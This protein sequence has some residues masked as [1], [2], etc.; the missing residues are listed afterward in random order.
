METTL[1]YNWPFALDVL[2][3][4]YDAIP[5]QRLLAFQSQY[6][7]KIGPNMRLGLFGQEGY[8]TTDP[9]NI[10]AI[11]S[12]HFEDWGL[13][14]RRPG[15]YPLL[16]EGIFTQEGKPWR[17]S[18]EILRRQ[19][20]RIQYQNLK[21]FD[22]H[23]NDLISG[24]TTA[25][26]DIVDLQ[27]FFFKFTLAT[28]TDLIF[29]EPVGMLDDDVQDTFAN[30][31]DYASMIS[32]LRLRLADFHWLYKPKKFRDACAVVKQYADHFVGQALKA[33]DKIGQEAAYEKYPFILDL[34][35]DLKDPFLV[36]DQ[37]VHVLIAGRDTT[38]C[39]MSWAMF[40]LVRHPEVLAKL[41]KQIMSVIPEAHRLYPQ[42]PVNVRIALRTTILPSGGGPD[43]KSPVLV[44]KGT[45]CGW[46]TYHMHRMTSLYGPG[47]NEF[48]PERWED[49]DLE[50]DIGWGFMPFHGGPRLCLGKDFALSEA[51]Y[52]LVKI[53][54]TFPNIRLPEGVRGEGTGMEKQNLTIVVTSAEGCKVLLR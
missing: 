38:A 39:L 26:D 46:S 4:Q 16:G 20:V 27:P 22:E 28:T 15:L 7:N 32:A 23:I 9:K 37:L 45:G 25:G 6:F 50:K 34:Y 8:M 33:R 44:R 54:Q 21:V 30:N 13:G 41:R 48:V 49:T 10:E 11:L 43:R 52:A 24:L 51:S 2:K 12:T 35:E 47:A 29:G 14:S 18:R 53:L 3:K 19:F 31:F 1:P 5:S 36:R 40:L 42:L 17:H